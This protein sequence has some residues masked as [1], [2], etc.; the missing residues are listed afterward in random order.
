MRDLLLRANILFHHG[1]N[2]PHRTVKERDGT[3]EQGSLHRKSAIER[4]VTRSVAALLW[5]KIG[6]GYG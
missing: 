6:D 4:P 3:S 2:C 1:G 5:P